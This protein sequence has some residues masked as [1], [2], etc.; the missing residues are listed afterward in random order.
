MGK[1]LLDRPQEHFLRLLVN[2]DCKNREETGKENWKWVASTSCMS[3]LF[4]ICGL[5]RELL[6]YEAG[7]S[8][9]RTIVL[10]VNPIETRRC[11]GF[12]HVSVR[13]FLGAS[14]KLRRATISFVISVCMKQLDSHWMDFHEMW[15]LRIFRNSVERLC[16]GHP[17]VFW[18]TIR[19]D[20]L[21]SNTTKFNYS[22]NIH[23]RATCFDLHQ[24]SSGPSIKIYR[25]ITIKMLKMYVG[26]HMLLFDGTWSLIFCRENSSFIKIWLE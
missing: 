17:E 22:F 13:K 2:V 26:S 19:R 20:Q 12:F 4:C 21:P 6:I 3:L 25:P 14:A 11:W 7:S 18:H 24:S 8:A 9:H 1:Y 5:L 10:R 23:S 15:H 16:I